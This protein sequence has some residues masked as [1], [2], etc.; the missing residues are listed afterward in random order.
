MNAN[1]N[2]ANTNAKPRTRKPKVIEPEVQQPQV[3]LQLDVEPSIEV[4]Q[5]QPE[6]EPEPEPEVQKPKRTRKPKVVTAD[7]DA[8]EVP[9]TDTADAP[10]DAVADAPAKKPRAP[11]KPK[12]LPEPVFEKPADEIYNRINTLMIN[13]KMPARLP[14]N[15]ASLSPIDSYLFAKTKGESLQTAAEKKIIRDVIKLIEK[16]DKAIAK[17]AK[18][19]AKAAKDADKPAKTNTTAKK[20]KKPTLTQIIAHKDTIIA[21]HTALLIANNISIPTTNTDADDDAIFNN[22]GVINNNNTIDNNTIDNNN[23]DV[24]P[25]VSNQWS[26]HFSEKQ[27]KPYWYNNVTKLSSWVKPIDF[28]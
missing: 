3:Q 23:D 19:A 1:T 14:A 8:P 9:V 16:D 5:P 4:Q 28:A 21:Q 18:D 7:A 2:T 11:R 22:T 20:S 10:A 15:Y 6:P 27:Q 26:Q 24:S 13:F 25:I 12:L 17:A